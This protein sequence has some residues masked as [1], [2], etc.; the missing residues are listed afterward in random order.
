MPKIRGVMRKHNKPKV[1]LIGAG[2][3]DPDLITLKAIKKLKT[4]QVVLYD[5]LINRSLLDHA[6]QAEHI[7]VGKRKGYQ[8]YSQAEINELLVKAAFEYGE[9]VRLKGGD[10]FVFGRG[11]EEADYLNLFGIETEIVPGISSALAVPASQGIPLTKRHVSQSFW[12]VTGTT[13]ENALS[14]DLELAVQSAA[15]IVIL[16]G[17]SKLKAIV[18]LLNKY[19]KSHVPAAIIQN[20]TTVNEKIGAGTVATLEEVKERNDLT[21]PA[22]IIIGAVVKESLKIE[23]FYREL[24]VK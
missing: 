3:G 20:G 13:S 22:I 5:A 14:A 17:M 24:A 9:V 21:A 8:K 15:T 23:A 7:F 2:P 4:A 19:G 16:M 6:P 18:A 10:P 12:V 1:S 11:A